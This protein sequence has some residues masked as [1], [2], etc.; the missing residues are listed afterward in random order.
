MTLAFGGFFVAVALEWIRNEL[1][2]RT[3]CG[4]ANGIAMYISEASIGAIVKFT[5]R[6]SGQFNRM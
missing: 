5:P 1:P 4:R 6:C 2:G 3:A